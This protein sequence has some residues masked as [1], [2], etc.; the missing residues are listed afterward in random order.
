MQAA[1]AA[2]WGS[3]GTVAHFAPAAASPVS[4]GAARIVAAG[5]LLAVIALVSRGPGA[6]AGSRRRRAAAAALRFGRPEGH[7]RGRRRERGRLPALLLL[8]GAADRGSDRDRGGHRQCPGAD[9]PDQPDRRRRRADPAVGGGDSRG[10]R[11]LRRPGH[12]RP[13]GRSE[14]GRSDPGAAGLALLR[15]L[16]RRRGPPDHRRLLRAR[17]DGCAVRRQRHSADSRFPGELAGLAADRPRPGRH[18]RTGRPR[19][20]GRLPALRAV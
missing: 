12:Q 4:V 10:H 8:R 3:T 18:G 17:G 20:R 13:G 19:H 14:P 9:R 6:A 11:R 7:S 2:L 15:Q 1:Q 16:C 5:A